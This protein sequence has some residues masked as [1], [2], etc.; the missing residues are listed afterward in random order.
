MAAD[1]APP[2]AIMIELAPEPEAIFTQDNEV[3]PDL[4]SAELSVP[5]EEILMPEETSLTEITEQIEPESGEEEVEPIEEDAVILPDGD[6]PL[7]V[8]RPKPPEPK[9]EVVRK[10]KL[11]AGDVPV[12]LAGGDEGE[13]PLG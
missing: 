8:A 9:K 4:V 12:A 5:A 11:L 10:G 7:P 6:V 1:E 3:A 13:N 2:A